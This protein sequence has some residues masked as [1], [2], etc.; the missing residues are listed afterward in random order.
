[1]NSPTRACQAEQR[2]SVDRAPDVLC[3]SESS[4]ESNHDAQ[5]HLLKPLSWSSIVL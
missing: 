3:P 2:K 5:G 4:S 1:M